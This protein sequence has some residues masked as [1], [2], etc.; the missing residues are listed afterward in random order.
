MTDDLD[1]TRLLASAALDNEVT[2]DERAQVAA[3]E[4]LT[5]AMETYAGLRDEIAAVDVPATSRESAIAAALAVFDAIQAGTDTPAA[6]AAAPL[7]ASTVTVSTQSANVISLHVRR[8]RQYRWVGGIAAAAVVAVLGVAVINR[9]KSGDDK[10]S[11]ATVASPRTETFDST[12]KETGEAASTPQIEATGGQAPA[13]AAAATTATTVPPLGASDS[14]QA[15]PSTA[16]SAET[17]EAAVDSAADTPPDPWAT[18]QA[19]NNV[20]DVR[21]YAL[22][23][24]SPLASPSIA[25]AET[26]A[27]STAATGATE[28]TAASSTGSAS[29][30]TAPTPP[31]FSTAPTGSPYGCDTAGLSFVPIVFL[32]ER[33]LLVRDDARGQFEIVDATTCE[34]RVSFPVP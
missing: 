31:P 30:T 1:P 19:F 26:T 3:S 18:A 12:A 6:A 10:Q 5:A 11:A 25:S 7:A 28:T 13:P 15:P 21:A 20:P 27:E 22:A 17:T 16:A 8:Q 14:G 4:S 34:V 23:P 9:S 2:A 33:A 24:G 29:T 32:G